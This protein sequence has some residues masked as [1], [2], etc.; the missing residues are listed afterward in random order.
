MRGQIRVSIR[1]SFRFKEISRAVSSAAFLWTLA[2]PSAAQELISPQDRAAIKTCR[3]VAVQELKD[4]PRQLHAVCRGI[5]LRLGPV[6]EFESINNEALQATLIDAHIGSSRRVL[7]VTLQDV[8]R[9]LLEDL[10][11]QIAFAAGRGP[12]SNIDGVE[13]D[14]KQFATIGEIG[15]RGRAADD[16]RGKADRISVGPQIARERARRVAAN[17]AQN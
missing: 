6:S 11:G 4:K 15:V 8:G 14:F 2:C 13:L 16:G 10:T 12:S 1:A 5:A 17:N 3:I 9:P 7:L